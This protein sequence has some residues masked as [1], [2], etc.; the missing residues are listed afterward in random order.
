MT[1]KG[2]YVIPLQ[3]LFVYSTRP[4]KRH[5][6]TGP[7]FLSL[8]L[9]GWTHSL[10]TAPIWSSVAC[11]DSV[12]LERV[13][14]ISLNFCEC[15]CVCVWFFSLY[16]ASSFQYRQLL[17]VVGVVGRW[18]YLLNSFKMILI[19]CILIFCRW[20]GWWSRP[21]W[22]EPRLFSSLSCIAITNTSLV[23]LYLDEMSTS[24]GV[25]WNF[26]ISN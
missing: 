11:G 2:T 4:H 10:S 16:Q 25:A 13:N 19:L 26:V 14:M 5:L 17:P 20:G 22:V 8:P 21:Q 1:F 12:S 23:V 24:N 7:C 18:I 6:S 9:L 3:L 15:V